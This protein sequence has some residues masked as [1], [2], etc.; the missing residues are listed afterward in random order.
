MK[1]VTVIKMLGMNSEYLSHQF[2]NEFNRGKIKSLESRLTSL[3]NRTEKEIH[4]TLQEEGDYISILPL[5]RE[6]D[7]DIFEEV[8]ISR[9]SVPS[10]PREDYVW[11]EYPVHLPRVLRLLNLPAYTLP[12]SLCGEGMGFVSGLVRKPVGFEDGK[13]IF[14]KPPETEEK[15]ESIES[16]LGKEE[17]KEEVE[18]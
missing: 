15:E 9:V 18:T 2:V 14:E 4:I 17:E 7:R 11:V 16:L 10:S 3:L 1:E 12:K 6:W 13:P 5:R 8:I